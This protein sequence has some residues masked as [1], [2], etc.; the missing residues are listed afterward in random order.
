MIKFF[1]TLIVLPTI[2]SL[3][4]L[5]CKHSSVESK[6][7]ENIIANDI[8]DFYNKMFR[9]MGNAYTLTNDSLKINGLNVTLFFVRWE[10][11]HGTDYILMRDNI[12]ARIFMIRNSRAGYKEYMGEAQIAKILSNRDPRFYEEA[13][14][15]Y[16]LTD[17]NAFFCQTERLGKPFNDY[18]QLDS[19]LS[20][21]RNLTRRIKTVAQLDSSLA[22]ISSKNSSAVKTIKEELTNSLN[23]NEVLIH[24]HFQYL[25][26]Y[27]IS[28]SN[29]DTTLGGEDVYIENQFNRFIRTSIFK[30]DINIQPNEN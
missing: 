15:K 2:C 8:L 11:S 18:N 7:T 26:I 22:G 23:K 14:F 25:S 28:P 19:L 24:D 6:K 4:I 30:I 16:P 1:L 27:G 17:L 21:K 10:A 5:N 9:G 13:M 12:T 3:S 29:Y 20:F